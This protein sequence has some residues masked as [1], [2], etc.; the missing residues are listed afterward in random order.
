MFRF[1]ALLWDPT[2]LEKAVTARTLERRLCDISPSWEVE[3]R[4]DGIS[5]LVAGH[6]AALRASRLA[7]GA[8]VVIGEIF[9]RQ[10]ADE[11]D[12]GSERPSPHASFGERETCEVVASHGR[13][14]TSQYWGNYVALVVEG[15]SRYVVKDPTGPLPCYLTE[16]RG[17][18]VMFSCLADCRE[19]GFTHF[20]LNWEFVRRRAV[21]GIFDVETDPLEGVSGVHR[22][23]CV[24][25]DDTGRMLSRS[26]YWHP[27]RFRGAGDWIE[28]PGVAERL[29]RSTVRHCVHSLAAHHSRLLQ[30][31]SGGLDSSI[32]LG[33]LG[34][35]PNEP[36]ITCYTAHL[37]D[38]VSDERRWARLAAARRGYRHIEVLHDPAKLMFAEMPA[39]EPSVEPSSPFTHWQRGPVERQLAIDHGASATFTGEGGDATFCSTCYV[40]AVDH[41]IARHGV[42]LRTLRTAAAVASRRDRTVWGVLAQAMRRRLFGSRLCEHRGTF[43]DAMRLV[44]GEAKESVKYDRFPNPWFSACDRIP[45]DTL[46]RLGPL[47]FRPSFYD[48]STSQ[49]EPSPPAVSPLCAQPVVE[50]AARIPVDIHFDGGRIRGLARRAFNRE[51]PEPILRRQWKDLP[52]LQA[53]EVIQLNLGFIREM[54]LDGALTRERILNRAAVESALCGSPTR[55]RALSGEILR[56]LEL[57][58]WIRQDL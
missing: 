55:S 52:V 53:G 6:S 35:A 3:Y 7:G 13:R 16:H 32:V 22:G 42:G 14:L 33:C 58:L 40:L 23:E 15:T 44:S 17:V 1:I 48:L 11:W 54:L 10:N 2:S 19:L 18:R 5:V 37:P 36:D 43:A 21:D 27:M 24:Q 12:G 49:H 31:T 30:Q 57:E 39:L 47:A 50:I 45:L 8:G 4:G 46:R 9:A 28:D 26:C 20:S 25:L 29:L 56:H 51:V 34:D 38:S 41:S